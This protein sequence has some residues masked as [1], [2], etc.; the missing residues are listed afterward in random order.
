MGRRGRPPMGPDLVDN[1]EGS[2]DAKERLK[3]IL[4][5][6]ALK[7]TVVEA[8]LELGI[9]EGM[10]YK[11]RDRTMADAI[12]SLEPRPLGRPPSEV[13]GVEKGEVDRLKEEVDRLKME[14][15]ASQIREE[16][17]VVMPH[18]LKKK[19]KR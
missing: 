4:E 16:M 15:R 6:I 14:L 8:C 19:P 11:L 10:F 12:E 9:S 1:M 13:M 7:K 17:A 18:V 3:V 5:T 2:P